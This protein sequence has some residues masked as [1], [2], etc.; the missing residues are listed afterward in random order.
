[1]QLTASTQRLSIQNQ[2]DLLE[3]RRT[4]IKLAEQLAGT[5]LQQAKINLA[6][7]E[8]TAPISGVIVAEMVEQAS[9][10]QKG[11]TLCMIHDTQQVEVS[12]NLRSD[13]W[14]LILDQ[15]DDAKKAE[16]SPA[17]SDSYELPP[18]PV[19]VEYRVGGRE[20]SLYQ[21]QGIISRYEGIGVNSQSRT[22]P[23]RITIEHPRSDSKWTNAW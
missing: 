18:T 17:T 6:R 15:K 19:T 3:T 13:Q 14:M 11:A 12:C 7:T 22:I 8:I 9:F 2:F 5:Q 4:R 1:M 20:E 10:I 16:T 21:W 23:I